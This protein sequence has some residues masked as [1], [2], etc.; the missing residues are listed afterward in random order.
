MKK[1]FTLLFTLVL[2]LQYLSA[3][4]PAS[5][6]LPL[7]KSKFAVMGKNGQE[8]IVDL[9]GQNPSFTYKLCHLYVHSSVTKPFSKVID[10][11]SISS[12]Q[13]DTTMR[14]T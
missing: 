4:S 6:M 1:S 2:S 12:T 10:F 5:T 13:T 3:G 11:S 9:A 7:S 8:K 14:S